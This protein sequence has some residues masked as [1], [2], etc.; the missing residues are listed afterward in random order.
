MP[1]LGCITPKVSARI[2]DSIIAEIETVI[3]LAD[4]NIM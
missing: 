3:I 4:K 2:Y 1:H